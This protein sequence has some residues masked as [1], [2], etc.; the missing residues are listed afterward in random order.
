MQKKRPEVRQTPG[1]FSHQD[2][3]HRAKWSAGFHRSQRD[4]VPIPLFTRSRPER[5]LCPDEKRPQGKC[6]AHV[7]EGKQ[8]TAE[9]L[10]GTKIEAFQTVLSRG[11]GVSTGALHPK[12]RA[13]R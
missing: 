12:E 7:E 6:C 13:L 5:L 4:P 2:S 8:E 3:P 1:R 9:A 10:K 11:K